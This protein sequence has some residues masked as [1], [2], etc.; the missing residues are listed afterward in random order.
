MVRAEQSRLGWG[1]VAGNTW[2]VR[3]LRFVLVGERRGTAKSRAAFT[4]IELIFV[5]VLLIVVASMVAPRMS[6]FFRGRVLSSEARRMLSLVNYA[7]SRAAAEGVPVLLWIDATNASYGI[8]IQGGHTGADDRLP[9]FVVEPSLR[10]EVGTI[11]TV[12][13]S[14]N[15]DEQLGFSENLPAIRFNPDGFFEDAVVNKII[16]RQGDEGALEIVPTAN[17]LSFEILPERRAN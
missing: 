12:N 17:R 6:S 15:G 7:Q 13:E 4:L 5:M 14:E 16:I 1:R 8:S 3:L 11:T 10:L 2:R 9:S